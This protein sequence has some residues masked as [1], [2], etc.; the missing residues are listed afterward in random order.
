MAK[1]IKS[2]KKELVKELKKGKKSG[3]IK[4]FNRDSFLNDLN[5]KHLTNK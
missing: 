5:K 4:N 3:F 2:K 1:Q